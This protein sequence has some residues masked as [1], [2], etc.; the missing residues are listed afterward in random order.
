MGMRFWTIAALA[1][2]VSGCSVVE[3]PPQIRGER[4]QADQL[5]ELTP[6][7]ATQ[8]D[9]TSLLGTPT[10]HA[11]FD[12][13]TWLYIFQ[14]TRPRV[15]ELPGVEDQQVVALQFDQA[16]VLRKITKRDADDAKT[17]AMSDAVPR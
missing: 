10:A 15:G 5:K 9:V 11:T 7:T 4:V 13:N 16:G 6:G 3:H 1:L 12:Q 14:V 2:C 17:V 8:A